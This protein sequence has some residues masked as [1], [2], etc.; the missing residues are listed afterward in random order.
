MGLPILTS[1]FGPSHALVGLLYLVAPISILILILGLVLLELGRDKKKKEGPLATTLTVLRGLLTNPV[2][3]MTI[4]GVLGNFAFSSAPPPHLVKFLSAL[5]AAFTALAPF[6]LGL[7]MAGKLRGI[8]SASIKPVFAL[9][10]MKS[11][12]TP[13]VTYLLV[14]RVTAWLDGAPSPLLTNFGL[15]FGSFP[16]ALAVASFATEYDVE[17][18]L[19]STAIVIGTIASAPLLY[20]IANILSNLSE[21]AEV[22][23]MS[24]HSYIDSILS[25]VSIALVLGLFLSRGGWRRAPNLL[26]LSLLLLTLLSSGAG[27]LLAYL[28]HP[29]L[30]ILHLTALH[31]S[32]LTTPALALRLLL[33]ARGSTALSSPAATALLLLTGPLLSLS[34]LL[35][36]LT[37]APPSQVLAFGPHQDYLSLGVNLSALVPTLACLALLTRRP[38]TSLPGVHIFRHTLLLLALATAMFVSLGLALGRAMLYPGPYPGAFRGLVCINNILSPG[39]GIL[40]LGV[41]GLDQAPRL[42]KPI[43][44]AWERVAVLL[45]NQDIVDSFVMTNGN[46]SKDG[47]EKLPMEPIQSA[48]LQMENEQKISLPT[49]RSV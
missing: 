14:G 42:V 40:F 18:E 13:L 16:T 29:G 19:V 9:V 8:R 1:V 38:P 7:S 44:V 26:T 35:L 37:P 32:R 10:T 22:L 31:A 34:T 28:P 47:P 41:F 12:V 2:V 3:A 46:N 43:K 33:L 24:D 23:S 15:L 45:I 20:A 21:S 30:A 11:I 49:G 17:P 39:Q 6:S 27:L 5:G 36:L 25:I 4:L 48:E